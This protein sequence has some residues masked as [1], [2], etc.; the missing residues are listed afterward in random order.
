MIHRSETESFKRGNSGSGMEMA[1]AFSQM[2]V[3]NGSLYGDRLK[4]YL[5][6]LYIY[7]YICVRVYVCMC[8]T[9]L[10]I[11]KCRRYSASS[12]YTYESSAFYRRPRRKKLTNGSD[13]S[14]L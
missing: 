13:R 3:F 2:C 6:S 10:F 1:S 4:Y 9:A 12:H 14:H 8:V 7:M 11:G 5:A